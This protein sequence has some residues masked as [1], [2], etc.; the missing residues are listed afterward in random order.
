MDW[1]NCMNLRMIKAELADQGIPAIE[2][3]YNNLSDRYG[4]K[5]DIPENDLN[6]MGYRMSGQQKHDLAIDYF[7]YNVKLY[8]GSA[9]V[10]DSL[11]EGYEAAGKQ[12]LARNNYQ[13]AV[14]KGT[15][16]GDNNLAVDKEHLE[17]V[18]KKI[19]E[20]KS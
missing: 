8:P 14:E 3:H 10:Y 12:D 9:N 2:D 19:Q 13:I 20:V 6:A 16:S 1:K 7:L 18:T 11:G 17:K 5:I 4:Y 15:E